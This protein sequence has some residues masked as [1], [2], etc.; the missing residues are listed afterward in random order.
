MTGIWYK[1]WEGVGAWL[2]LAQG[3]MG[4]RELIHLILKDVDLFPHTNA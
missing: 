3:K 2:A 1:G 4:P